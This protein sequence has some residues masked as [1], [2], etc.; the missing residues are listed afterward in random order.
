MEIDITFK[1]FGTF[2]TSAATSVESWSRMAFVHCSTCTHTSMGACQRFQM[3]LNTAHRELGAGRLKA[4]IRLCLGFSRVLL[5]LTTSHF[6]FSWSWNKRG[7]ASLTHSKMPPPTP[8]LHH[9]SNGHICWFSKVC[10]SSSFF[11]P[12]HKNLICI[13]RCLLFSNSKGSFSC[14]SLGGFSFL[15]DG[16]WLLGGALSSQVA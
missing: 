13:K 4:Q 7:R 12:Q 8:S 16:L 5:S 11:S 9:Y 10:S 3:S 6:K 14:L 15:L 1:A 2:P